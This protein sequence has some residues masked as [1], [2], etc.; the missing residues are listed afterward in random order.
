MVLLHIGADERTH[1]SD[2]E[3]LGAR[4][5]QHAFDK[6]AADALPA[7]TRWHIH[8]GQDKRVLF[9]AI[10]EKSGLAFYLKLKARFFRVVLN[11]ACVN[12]AL[13]GYLFLERWGV[14]CG[15]LAAKRSITWDEWKS[16]TET[17]EKKPNVD[18]HVSG[19]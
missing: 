12:L 8:V 14:G 1:G 18:N 19:D 2:L 15:C 3:P 6:L 16:K 7:Q 5:V 11:R 4:A 9:T 17:C 13:P 10:V